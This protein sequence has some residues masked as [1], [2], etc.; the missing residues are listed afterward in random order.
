VAVPTP[1]LAT[2]QAGQLLTPVDFEVWPIEAA[3]SGQVLQPS[4][5]P[6][7]GTIVFAEGESPHVGH[8]ETRAETDA[9]GNYELLVPE[10][11]YVVGA[12]L[13]GDELA[14]L[15]WLNPAPIDVPWV[16]TANPATG[17]D[18]QFR[19]LDG[20]ISGAITFAP[21]ILMTPTHPAYVW[22]W[23][24]TGEWAETEAMVSGPQSFTYTLRVV[25]NTTWHIGAVY[26]DW[27]KGLFYE[28]PEAQVAV[29]TTPSPVA[30]AV[31]DLELGGPWP[32][33]QPFII[34]F[35]GTQMQTIMMPDGVELRIPA[36]AMVKSGTVTMFIFPTKEL[37]PEAGKEMIGVGYEMWAVDQ[38][39]QQITKFNKNVIMTFSYPPD[40]T[41][42]AQG[43][44]ENLLLPVYFSTLAGK[45]TLAESY[46]V[47]TTNN[48]ITLQINH[49]TK[50]GLRATKPAGTKIY[51]PLLFKNR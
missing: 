16:S 50:F 4:G 25:S 12:A 32:L 41:L 3:I 19:A 10:G 35:D 28:S 2:V 7:S 33:P 48:E 49:F 45:W 51:L 18:L 37:R 6:L 38:N 36:G 31:Q 29:G 24:D 5:A 26:E 23:A 8:F 15:G 44:S 11:G 1:T 22:G 27:D 21:G 30:L 47:D 13:P 20:E 46:V 17:V 39:G 14:A 43:I 9:A 34:S 40:A 42:E